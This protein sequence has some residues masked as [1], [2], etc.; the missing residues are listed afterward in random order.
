MKQIPA[1]P[2]RMSG[3]NQPIEFRGFDVRINLRAVIVLNLYSSVHCNT[4]HVLGQV[5]D[6]LK[7]KPLPPKDI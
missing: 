3:K 6:N 7:I 4:L 2:G 5:I 1:D